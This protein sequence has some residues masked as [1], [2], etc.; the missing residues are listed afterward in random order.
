MLALDELIQICV[1]GF[2]RNKTEHINLG[3]GVA[4]SNAPSE[5]LLQV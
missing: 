4:L 1:K 5:T 3:I 2:F